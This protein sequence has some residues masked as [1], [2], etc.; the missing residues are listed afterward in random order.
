MVTPSQ[1][2]VKN[3]TVKRWIPLKCSLVF[4]G[5]SR[6]ITKMKNK[7]AKSIERY[8]IQVNGILEGEN[9]RTLQKYYLKGL[10]L[11]IVQN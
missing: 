10:C 11:R 7:S 6:E 8:I 3:E 4:E 1:R 2:V 5:N 9:R